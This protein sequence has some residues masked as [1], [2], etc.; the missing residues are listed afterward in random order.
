MILKPTRKNEGEFN[1]FTCKQFKLGLNLLNHPIMAKKK[2]KKFNI[3]S[4][5]KLEKLQW[6]TLTF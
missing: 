1:S 4:A 5:G 3:T 6:S 2:K